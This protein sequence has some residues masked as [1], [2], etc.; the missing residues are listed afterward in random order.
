MIRGQQ[1]EAG[2]NNLPS[3]RHESWRCGYTR[4]PSSIALTRSNCQIFGCAMV[5]SPHSAAASLDRPKPDVCRMCH[6]RFAAIVAVNVSV[7][8]SFCT[9]A[10]G[11]VPRMSHLV[12]PGWRVP[13]NPHAQG[14]VRRPVHQTQLRL[15]KTRRRGWLR[16]VARASGAHLCWPSRA[17][18][19]LPHG[20]SG[21]TLLW[22][23]SQLRP[24]NTAGEKIDATTG[25]SMQ[26]LRST[27]SDAVQPTR[28]ILKLPIQIRLENYRFLMP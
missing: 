28:G 3:R 20:A 17:S 15:P 6:V 5:I 18:S 26:V 27:K 8:G 21:R 14:V 13:P 11:H 1:T 19:H 2:H 9:F 10:D 7:F 24:S 23:G 4:N 12:A 16:T 25:W 22:W